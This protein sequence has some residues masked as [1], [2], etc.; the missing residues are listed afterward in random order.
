MNSK[1]YKEQVLEGVLVNYWAKMKEEREDLMFQQDGARSHTSKAT[2]K[3]FRQHNI[4]LFPHPA[5]SPDVSPID[6]V[7]HVLKTHVRALP[8]PPTTIQELI[9]VVNH[10]WDHLPLSDINKYTSSMPARVQAVLE[11][12]GGPTKF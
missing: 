11:A 12:N 10:I 7:W 1:R 9:N 8:H 4:P 2:K 3:W 5:S 6:N